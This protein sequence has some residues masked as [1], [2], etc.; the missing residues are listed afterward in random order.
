[1]SSGTSLGPFSQLAHPQVHSPTSPGDRSGASSN[2]NTVKN[3]TKPD[4][5]ATGEIRMKPKQS[6]SRNGENHCP[7]LLEPKK[8]KKTIVAMKK[9]KKK[10]KR[11]V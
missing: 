1:M 2:C 4:T 8:K 7:T 11:K 5:V 10:K 9:E 6:K 3:P